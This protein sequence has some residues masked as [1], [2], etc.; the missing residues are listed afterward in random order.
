M[1]LMFEFNDSGSFNDSGWRYLVLKIF[2]IL[3]IISELTMETVR[4]KYLSL[5][6]RKQQ[7]ELLSYLDLWKFVVLPWDSLQGRIVLFTWSAVID[8]S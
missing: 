4:V 2:L 8:G 3:E 6:G 5:I 1:Q 7:D